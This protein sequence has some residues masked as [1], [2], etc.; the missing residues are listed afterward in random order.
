MG[1]SKG[2]PK[3][4]TSSSCYTGLETIFPTENLKTGFAEAL[5]TKPRGPKHVRSRLEKKGV[6]NVRRGPAREE[7][8]RQKEREREAWAP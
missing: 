4:S 1:C 2:V 5:E 3:D 7:G 6:E 8:G